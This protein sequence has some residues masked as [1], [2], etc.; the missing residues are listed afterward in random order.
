MT[1][2]ED[3]ITV[4]AGAGT[5]KTWV[6]AARFARLLLSGR[7]CLPRNIL[8]LT[9]TEAAAREMQDRIRTHALGL[10]NPGDDGDAWGTVDRQAVQEGFDEAWISTIHSFASRLIRESG[11]S[12]DIDPRSGIVETPMEDAFW[13]S[14]SRAL[15]TLSLSALAGAELARE[16]AALEGD[17]VLAA[18]LE[19]WEASGLCGLARGVIELHASLG[20]EPSVLRD[21]ADESEREG[22]P[23]ARIV[24]ESVAEL[25]R[26]R[27]REAWDSWKTIFLDLGRKIGNERGKALETLKKSA[28]NARPRPAVALA[29]VMDRWLGPMTRERDAFSDGAVLSLEDWEER[30]LFFVDLCANLSGNNSKLFGEI[31]ER[32]GRTASIWRDERKKWASLSAPKP[33]A[34]LPE[35][36]RKLRASLLRLCAFA[37]ELWDGAKRRAGLLSFSDMIRFAAQ[38][39]EKDARPKG[40][41]HVLIDEFQD[42]DPL[43][44]SMIR[45]LREKEG[46]KLFLV[47]DPKQAIYRFRHAD[48]TLFAD[49]VLRSRESRSDIELGVSFRTRAALLDRLNSLFSHIWQNGLGAGAR[50]RALTFNPLSPV[51]DSDTE[52]NRATVPP[53]SLLLSAV[54]GRETAGPRERLAR[55]L[56][57]R[58]SRWVREGRTVWEKDALRPVQWR[59]FAVLTPTRGEYAILETAFGEEG[60][61]AAFE[62]SKGY[63]SRGEVTDVVN[64]LRTAAFPDDETALAGWLASP[65]SGT[66]QK[67][68]QELLAAHARNRGPGAHFLSGRPSLGR[69]LEER[70]PAAAERAENLRRIGALKGP[71]AVLSHLLEDR[72]WLSAFGAPLR[73]AANV[74]RA[75]ALARQYEKGVSASL[76]GCAQWLD[77]A[78]RSGGA[79][80]EP[81]WMD[82]ADAVRVMTV[83]AAKGLEFPVVAVMRTERGARPRPPATA[84]PSRGM[85]VAIS[86]FPDR[87]RGEPE[88]D[89]PENKEKPLSMVWERAL[90]EQAELEES[91]RLF[92]V[93]ATRARDSLVLCGLAR[94]GR[95]GVSGVKDES[96]LG[97]TLRWLEEEDGRDGHA[98]PSVLWAEPS[99]ETENASPASLSAAPVCLRP[100]ALRSEFSEDGP[101]LSDLSATS[102]ALFEWCPFAW[103]RRS[104]QGLDLRWEAPDDLDEKEDGTG[105]ADLGSLA[106]WLLARWDMKAETLQDWLEE[107]V[108]RSLPSGLR[109]AWR[110][111][112][113]RE[114][115]RKW[116][117]AFSRSD[118][119]QILAETLRRGEL[120]RESAFRVTPDTGPRL[121]GAM[122]AFWRDGGRW[123]VRDYKITL[124]DNAP[125]EL[126]RAQLAFYALVVKLLA[127]KSGLPFESVDTGLIFLREGGHLGETREFRSDWALPAR[128]AETSALAARGPWAPRREHCRACPWRAGCPK[129]G[130]A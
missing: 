14:F 76:A 11:L 5:G 120:R 126:Y 69:L 80:E 39:V 85:G 38:A 83:H 30:R 31:A 47:G 32:L 42:T 88:D 67:E 43:Q 37:W 91:T 27:W 70:L 74:G 59:D 34:P 26:P 87:M 130:K 45:A 56:A 75:L 63:F 108:A 44:D 25:L 114:A 19:K 23:R 48:L 113:N 20:H 95:E 99:V 123:H 1:C 57:R 12:L 111:G 109:G 104:R 110:N 106:H 94:E 54:S 41:M 102:F 73:V 58:F 71:S 15:D 82:A 127:E 92:Y 18:A 51:A 8:T 49:Y 116:L 40:F 60:V 93:A 22:D 105:G 86:E 100:L 115:L 77:A 65:F 84:V 50:M 17:F 35:A 96:W 97:W 2:D 107:P 119:G 52:R 28:E 55:S 36:E 117:T 46:A 125:A 7:G 64:T 124:S 3:L 90:S 6:L 13:D 129:R 121:V 53:F 81:D 68:V 79:L 61:P 21:W 33:G 24:W 118:E 103:R 4:G 101:V 72:R 122:D 112:K 128:I 98:H 10:L 16:A 62:K 78:L 89:G 66:P 29:G 9:Y